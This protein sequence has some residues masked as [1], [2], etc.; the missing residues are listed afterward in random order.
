MTVAF[1]SS[2]LLA[3][4]IISTGCS[5]RIELKIAISHYVAADYT[6]QTTCR[7]SRESLPVRAAERHQR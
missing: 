7:Q 5:L 1:S 2:V 4:F 6:A 3:S